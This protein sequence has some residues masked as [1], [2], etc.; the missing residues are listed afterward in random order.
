MQETAPGVVKYVGRDVV[1][2][3][4]LRYL[5]DNLGG[6]KYFALGFR[7]AK[8]CIDYWATKTLPIPVPKPFTTASDT[9]LTF[10]RLP[11]DF[12]HTEEPTPTFDQLLKRMGTDQDTLVRLWIGSLFVEESDQSSYLWI[13]GEGNDGK[14]RLASVLGKIFGP[15]YLGSTVPDDRNMRFWTHS[16]LGK[17]LVCFGECNNYN[18]PMT[19]LFKSI[20]GGDTVNVEEKGKNMFS[21]KL[22]CRFLFLSNERPGITGSRANLRR[23]LYVKMRPMTDEEEKN[24]MPAAEMESRLWDEVPAFIGRCIAEYRSKYPHHAPIIADDKAKAGL[25]DLVAE[26]EELLAVVTDRYFTQGDD[27]TF[28]LSSKMIEIRQL[29]KMTSVDYRNWI[30]YLRRNYKIEPH[31]TNEH[32]GW[33][34]LRLKDTTEAALYI[35]HKNETHETTAK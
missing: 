28:V 23:A 14:G 4:L 15:A 32:R 26:N 17:R 16:L 3:S 19:A 29:E 1:I 34:R 12:V 9:S 20:T 24:R 7:Q 25:D 11:F 30:S 8:E 27:N 5:E 18:F 33:R 21:T 35:L 2:G 10:H 13:Y 6:S 22:Q 31:R